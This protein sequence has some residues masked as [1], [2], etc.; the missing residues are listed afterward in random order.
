MKSKNVEND[1]V[2]TVVKTF[3]SVRDGWTFGNEMK[4][5]IGED[6]AAETLLQSGNMVAEWDE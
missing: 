6:T 1:G 2:N 4:Q 3:I 5:K